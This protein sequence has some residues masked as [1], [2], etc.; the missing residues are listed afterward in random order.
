M[1]LPNYIVIASPDKLSLGASVRYI[2]GIVGKSY[3]VGEMHS[4]MSSDSISAYIGD[5]FNQYDRAI[6]T[7][8]ARKM[9]NINPIDC[10]PKELFNKVDLV[11]WFNLYATEMNLLKKTED[12]FD[13]HLTSN[14]T[15][16]VNRLGR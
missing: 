4:L 14:W 6:I 8:Y 10:V 13:D 9:I 1:K 7:Y 12:P 2:R 3:M 15:D 11:I 5:F 16:Y